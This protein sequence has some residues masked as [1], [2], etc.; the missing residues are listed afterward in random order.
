[1]IAGALVLAALVCTSVSAG[2][3]TATVAGGA[4]VSG[5]YIVTVRHPSRLSQ[6]IGFPIVHRFADGFAARLSPARL[7][8][9]RTDPEVASVEPDRVVRAA[10]TEKWP[11]WGL[12]RIDEKQLPLSRSYTFH[13][14]GAGVD[15]Y[16][17]DTGVEA[18]HREFGG[19]AD[20]VYGG[21]DCNGHGTHAAGI[22]GSTSYGVAKKARLHGVR[23]LDCAGAG[24]TSDV[25]AGVEWVRAHHAARSIADLPL[26]S[27]RSAAL[28]TAVTRLAR[29]GVFVVT[30]AGNDGTDACTRSPA[31]AEHVETAAASATDDRRAP[32][33][34]YGRCVDVYAPGVDIASAYRHG[35]ARLSGTSMA[36]SFVAG[37][38][39]L[40]KSAFGQTDT[41]TVHRWLIDH[42]TNGVIKGNRP[43]THN[44]LLN[45]DSL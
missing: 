6:V 19:R 21:P 4:A 42:A 11:G 31:S 33:S 34:D 44:R 37:V 26:I 5:R 20:T 9:L 28:N 45:K 40:Y 38:A 35:T 15:A 24:T 30:A 10:T 29:S 39:V 16:V 8:A 7:A 3:G 2:A 17:I 43:G 25:I 18:S 36:S 14:T 22:I 27:A 13:H 41:D 32:F 23:V 1:V 12:D